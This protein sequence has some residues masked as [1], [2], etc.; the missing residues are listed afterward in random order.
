MKVLSRILLFA[1]LLSGATH[2]AAQSFGLNMPYVGFRPLNHII[3]RYNDSR[4]WLDNEMN[5]IHLMPGLTFAV[6]SHAWDDKVGIY[7]MAWRIAGRT[8]ESQGQD[9]WRKLRVRMSTFSIMGGAFTCY[10]NESLRIAVGTFPV[11]L[12]NFRVKTKTDTSEDGYEMLWRSTN[13]LGIPIN[14][15]STFFIDFGSPFGDK[16]IITLRAFAKLAWWDDE[17]LIYVNDA[18]NPLQPNTMLQRQEMGTSHFG[19]Q[20]LISA[21]K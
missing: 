15:S 2:G 19:F 20:L 18:L 14:A 3:D 7:L 1:L 4:P 13:I 8:V 5:N 6:G 16:Q 12:T 11:E 10:Q 21:N 9:H 17:K